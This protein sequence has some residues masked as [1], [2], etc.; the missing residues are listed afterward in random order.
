MN[1]N[2]KF[3]AATA[4]VDEAAVR[5]LARRLS[6]YLVVMLIGPA[7][8]VFAMVLLARVE[9]SDALARLHGLDLEAVAGIGAG[10]SG[11]EREQRQRARGRE[12]A[13]SGGITQ[14]G[15][16]NVQRR[17]ERPQGSV[18]PMIDR[19]R[20]EPCPAAKR[21]CAPERDS[22]SG[23]RNQDDGGERQ[24]QSH[25]SP[26][27]RY[28]SSAAAITPTLVSVTSA[29]PISTFEADRF[30]RMRAPASACRVEGGRGAQ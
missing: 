9:A 19:E 12:P 22:E 23:G 29:L 20:M 25:R 18:Q 21:L 3:L 4:H 2:P 11:G 13:P 5:S 28:F 24:R 6:E 14:Q 10:G 27:V 1:A 17:G 7:I 15:T 16:G 8:T 30:S 26:P